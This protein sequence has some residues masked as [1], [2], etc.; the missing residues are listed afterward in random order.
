MTQRHVLIGATVVAALLYLGGAIAL[1]TPPK[2]TDSPAQVLTWFGDHQDAA[3]W[4]AW[5]AALGGLAFCVFAGIVRGLLPSPVGHVFLLGAAAFVVETAVQ[6]WIWGALALHPATLEPA[7]ARTLLDMAIFWGPILTGATT[8]MIGAVTVL[9]FG[10][11]PMIPRWLLALGVIAFIEQAIET[12][13][14]FGTHGFIA[15]GGPMNVVLGAGLTVIWLIGVVVWAAGR[16]A[17]GVADG[18]GSSP[19]GNL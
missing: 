10:E 11:R 14:V 4:Y 3:R 5:T 12:I 15:P 8:A 17:D 2:A 1:G 18:G 7:T 19:A 6:A 9:G 16:L 13:T